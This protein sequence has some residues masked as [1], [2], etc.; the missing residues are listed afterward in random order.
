MKQ[1]KPLF[2]M[3]CMT[4]CSK[5][6]AA[7]ILHRP[8]TLF[9]EAFAKIAPSFERA[10]IQTTWGEY[11][12]IRADTPRKFKDTSPSETGVWIG[13]RVLPFVAFKTALERTSDDSTIL[14]QAELRFPSKDN[15]YGVLVTFMRG[16]SCD[17]KIISVIQDVIKTL[18]K[19]SQQDAASN[20]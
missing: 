11:F 9:S 19:E 8:L 12:H 13:V 6:T 10:E 2:F 17:P 7:D 4:F 20:P 14:E 16:R 3:L 18:E 1:L 15:T 5:S